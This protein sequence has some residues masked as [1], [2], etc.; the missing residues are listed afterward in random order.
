MS[1]Q[2]HWC[3]GMEM[4]RRE[5]DGAEAESKRLAAENAALREQLKEY[6]KA[7]EVTLFAA[8]CPICKRIAPESEIPDGETHHVC[9]RL[10]WRVIPPEIVTENAALREKLAAAEKHAEIVDRLAG[11]L[12]TIEWIAEDNGDEFCVDC[13]Q[14]RQHE[15]L[16]GCVIG[17]ALAAHEAL[18]GGE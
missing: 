17:D 2:T 10:I 4:Y 5:R 9:G 11:A 18:G 16:R 14:L 8:W 1:K 15:H 6:H 12:R 13:A 3:H 7:V